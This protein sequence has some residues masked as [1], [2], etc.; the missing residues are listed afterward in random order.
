VVKRLLA[1]VLLLAPPAQAQT[2]VLVRH[3]ERA[4]AP[5]ADP[6]ITPRAAPGL[7]RWPTF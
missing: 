2:V 4:A 1:V 7:R 3:A 6:G 5:A